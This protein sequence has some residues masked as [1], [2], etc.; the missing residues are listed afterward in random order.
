MHFGE[1][2]NRLDVNNLSAR[3]GWARDLMGWHTISPV[4]LQGPAVNITMCSGA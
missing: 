2:A 3:S 1:F 4:R